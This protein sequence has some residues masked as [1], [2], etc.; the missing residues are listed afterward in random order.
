MNT[1]IIAISGFRSSGKDTAADIIVKDF[2]ATKL[3]FAEPL[4]K[5]VAIQ[6]NLP[7]I[8]MN[9]P[10]LKDLPLEDMPLSPKDKFNEAIHSLLREELKFGYWT[11]RA[12]TILEG[13]TK[14]SVNPDYWATQVINRIRSYN[15][16]EVAAD[17]IFGT[18]TN[19]T[20]Y[21]V[22]DLRFK[23]EAEQL[24][25]NFKEN[26][27]LIRINRFDEIDSTDPSERDLDDYPFDV[28]V[29]NKSTKDKFEEKIKQIAGEFLK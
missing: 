17:D 7:I 28:I 20:I 2:N 27:L 26:L 15:A 4:K 8:Y 14:R 1:K 25:R 18:K 11:P 9:D 3:S 5:L 19:S 13:S 21:V 12:L 22:S 24:K 29:E 6:Y 23:N 10:K 16:Y